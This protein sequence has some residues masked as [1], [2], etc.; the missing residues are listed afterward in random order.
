[1]NI[2][3]PF[4]LE[5]MNSTP[6]KEGS[7]YLVTFECHK[8]DWDRFIDAETAGIVFEAVVQPTHSKIELKDGPLSKEADSLC[9]VKNWNE[10]ASYVMGYTDLSV[11]I[12]DYCKIT[13][14]VELDHDVAAAWKFNNLKSKMFNWYE[15]EKNKKLRVNETPLDCN[16]I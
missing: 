13:S 11:L 15:A 3:K 6:T 14:H 1:M 9:T 2:T 5:L 10:Y 7:K 8:P 12:I 16:I 4:N